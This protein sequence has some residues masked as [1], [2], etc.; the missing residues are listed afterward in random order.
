MILNKEFIHLSAIGK[1]QK[2]IKNYYLEFLGYSFLKKVG[3]YFFTNV[4]YDSKRFTRLICLQYILRIKL[5]VPVSNF[6]NR[7]NIL[8]HQVLSVCKNINVMFGVIQKQT[9]N[10]TLLRS[11]FVYKKSREQLASDIITRE[12]II[13]FGIYSPGFVEYLENVFNLYF[14][15]ESFFKLVIKKE[16]ISI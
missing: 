7:M 3:L 13:N 11:P 14:K 9:R 8:I 10:Y 16:L 5:S 4:L 6:L 1:K 12:I 15:N 2:I